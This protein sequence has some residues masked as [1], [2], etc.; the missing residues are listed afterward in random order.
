MQLNYY[1]LERWGLLWGY[2]ANLRNYSNRLFPML[3]MPEIAH[4]NS[5][6]LLWILLSPFGIKKA[7]PSPT[8]GQRWP[9]Y[10]M[11]ELFDYLPYEILPLLAWNTCA[12]SFGIESRVSFAEVKNNWSQR[13]CWRNGGED[14]LS[15]EQIPCSYNATKNSGEKG[16][17]LASRHL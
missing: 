12:F 13:N 3:D 17:K 15:I 4:E 11:T 2:C 9:S 7:L 1:S 5:R 10:S 8:Y 14:V 6:G 16:N